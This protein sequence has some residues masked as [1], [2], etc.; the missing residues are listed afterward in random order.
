MGL[1]PHD[2]DRRAELDLI[3]EM[4]RRTSTVF[5]GFVRA[6]DFVSGAIHALRFP[7]G[8]ALTRVALIGV[9]STI[10]CGSARSRDGDPGKG[11]WARAI[12]ASGSASGL[13]VAIDRGGDIVVAGSFSGRLAI[14]PTPLVSAGGLDG[15]V[16][17]LARDGTPRWA[18]RF[19][20][21]GADRANAVGIDD[22]G[23]IVVA[24]E[25]GGPAQIGAHSATGAG[26][27]NAFAAALSAAGAFGWVTT[28]P[29]GDYAVPTSIAV[30][31]AGES[32]I[33]GYFAGSIT[34]GDHVVHSA[35]SLDLFVVRLDSG[36]AV[37][38]IRRAGGLGADVAR[39]VAFGPSG[40]VAVAGSVSD[41]VELGG[42]ALPS[43]DTDALVALLDAAGQPSWARRY[44]DTGPDVA[45]AIAFTG[46]GLAAAGSFATRIMFGPGTELSGRGGGDGF[47]LQLSLAGDPVWTFQLAGSGRDV[48]RAIGAD[49]GDI[50]V[51]G[52]FERRL[53]LRNHALASRGDADIW[54][55][56]VSSS[57]Q[58][59]WTRQ[60]GGKAQD[61][62]GG[63]AIGPDHGIAVTG[64][65]RGTATFGTN[66][67]A[68][69][70]TTAGFVTRLA[71]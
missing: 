64:S 27:S 13:A 17:R 5:F 49:G 33:G 29:G 53:D 61:A 24:G 47:V 3:I 20:G 22:S 1:D 18:V 14:T 51:A 70:Q 31:G 42:I 65:F 21:E 23:A 67:L 68:A 32:V 16:A 7:W 62:V 26:T 41:E 34:A 19:G 25:L 11:S 54:V 57:G 60:L 66:N 15:F 48:A 63:I 2:R 43:G 45:H 50:V 55:A 59:A 36:G 40:Q 71:P 4:A 39:A 30:S 35:G 12:G 8:N 52:T 46:G 56:R 69:A 28:F 38:W 10:A 37:R 9:M 44:G 6:R 58:L